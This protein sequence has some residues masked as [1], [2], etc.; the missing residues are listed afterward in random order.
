MGLI[1]ADVATRGDLDRAELE[2]IVEARLWASRRTWTPAQLLDRDGLADL[3]RRMFNQVWT[4]AGKWRQREASIGIA[5]E[6]IQVGLHDLLQDVHAWIEC[7]TFPPDE[8][9]I[10]FHHRLVFIHPF[11]N[12]NGRHARLA[13]DLLAVALGQPA[14]SWSERADGTVDRDAY[15]R[16]LQ[17]LDASREDADPLLAF[18]RG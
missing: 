1:P 13:A 10:L 2:N 3:H 17:V 6:R 14:F 8:I 7:K 18:A 15:R 16:A 5:P 4:W 9:A 11:P 12:G